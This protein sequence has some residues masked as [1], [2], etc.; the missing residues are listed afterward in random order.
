MD[1]HPYVSSLLLRSMVSWLQ[2]LE[3]SAQ[4]IQ[5]Q[6]SRRRPGQSQL[7][8]AVSIESF[9]SIMTNNLLTVEKRKRLGSTPIRFGTRRNIG[10][11]NRS[12]RQ[13]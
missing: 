10:H 7:T 6:L 2:G 4:D 3:L 13:K 8:T 1:A 11:T 9:L 12:S 5:V